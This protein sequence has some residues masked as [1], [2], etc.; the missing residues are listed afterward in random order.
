MS[1]GGR[2]VAVTG[3]G[4]FVGRAAIVQIAAAG[5]G[6]KHVRTRPTLRDAARADDIGADT[7]R[8]GVVAGCE[9]MVHLA[10][11]A[12]VPSRQA[13]GMGD[14]PYLQINRD[15]TVRLAREAVRTGVGRFIFVSSS[16]VN[17]D[18][19]ERPYTLGDEPEPL[20]AYARSK[21]AA[22]QGL[23]EIARETG[24][25]VV[26]IRPPVIYGPGVK[27]NFR[28]MIRAV[29]QGWPLPLGAIDNLRSICYAGNVGDL[30]ARCLDHPDAPGKTFY[31]ADEAPLST[32]ELVQRLAAALGKKSR[33]LN[34]S[35]ALLKLA[36]SILGRGEQIER[37]ASS[38]IL[39][40]SET[41]GVLGWKPP[42][43]TE[44]GLAETAK[45]WRT[46]DA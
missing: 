41:T 24:L 14:E 35:P 32:P 31:V 26:I 33:L 23:H 30:I 3:A 18:G 43:S 29:D 42:Y 7:D 44:E 2:I 36:G 34:V 17:G 25:E 4:G 5:F 11:L 21:W 46:R 12:H 15:L 39:D 37:L 9:A 8:T 22:E 13:E 20:D 19:R 27:A 28:Q 6:V 10:G 40:T 45:W 1:G 38:F 16:K